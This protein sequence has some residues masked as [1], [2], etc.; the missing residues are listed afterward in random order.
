[1]WKL[2]CVDKFSRMDMVIRNFL[3]AQCNATAAGSFP[4]EV[5]LP[6]REA[7]AARRYKSATSL[8]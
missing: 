1:M 2:C 5:I 3:S 8:S 4:P 6:G 7:A